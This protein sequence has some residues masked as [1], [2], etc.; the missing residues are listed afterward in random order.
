[1]GQRTELAS[2]PFEGAPLPEDPE[3]LHM[4]KTFWGSDLERIL[5]SNARSVVPGGWRIEVTPARPA[6]ED[7]FLHVMEIGDAGETRA[8]RIE[9]VAGKGLEGA[10]VEGGTLALFDAED[11]RLAEGEVTLPDV[12]AKTLVLSG[13]A[14]LARYDLQLTPN[15][16]PGAPMWRQAV[17]ADESGLVHLAWDGRRN[18]RLRLRKDGGHE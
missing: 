3:L 9:S 2:V 16:N 1:V 4:W 17:E 14:P 10:V 11:A 7:H 6:R 18:A 15:S 12:A 13:L 5:P 8:R